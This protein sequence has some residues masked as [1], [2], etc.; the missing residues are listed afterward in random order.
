MAE[1]GDWSIFQWAVVGLL[2]LMVS[3]IHRVSKFL[4]EI[5]GELRLLN[6][7]KGIDGS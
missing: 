5:L 7:Y 4:V 3:G 1:I 6:H 2:A